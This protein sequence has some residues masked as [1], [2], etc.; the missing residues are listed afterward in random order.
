MISQRQGND[1]TSTKGPVKHKL[2]ANGD[3]IM[4]LVI[5]DKGKTFI[6]TGILTD[7]GT[8]SFFHTGGTAVTWCGKLYHVFILVIVP[9]LYGQS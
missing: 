6:H 3:H 8:K 7:T 4:L 1:T 2:F 5:S 9:Y